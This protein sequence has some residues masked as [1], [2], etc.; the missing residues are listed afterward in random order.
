MKLNKIMLAVSVVMGMSSL[1]H[2]ADPVHSAA[3]QGHGKV[4]FHGS[5]I[6]AP[7]SI[8]PDSVDQKIELGEISNVA[9]E[10][11]GSSTPKPFQILLKNCSTA[12]LKTVTSTFTG[13]EGVDGKLGITGEAAG[14]GIVLTNGD[15][16][17]I[18]L[19]KAT[20][21]QTIQNGNNTLSFSAYVQGD[22]ASVTPGEFNSIT[23]F[24][25]AYQ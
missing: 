10:K 19:G 9:L 17:K 5:I 16:T 6:D 8:D 14:A 1:A 24:T 12:T 4:T 3:D 11:S 2:A 22:G 21:A 15:G 7:C 20:K 18:T 23:D 13:A 25:L